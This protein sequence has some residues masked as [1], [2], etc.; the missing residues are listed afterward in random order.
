M[1]ALAISLVS[2]VIFGVGLAVSQMVDP[3][4]VLAF[5][6]VAGRWDPSLMFVMGGGILVF[7]AAYQLIRHRGQ[8]LLAGRF[9]VPTAR[10]IDVRLVG[11]S[12]LFGVGWGLVGYCPGPAMASLAFGLRESLIFVAAAAAGAALYKV[13]PGPDLPRDQA[14]A[15]A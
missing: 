13:V 7:G 1:A 14:V 3:A 5:L 10:D 2:G 9:A 11:G 4:K 8:P 15:G 6:D 12:V